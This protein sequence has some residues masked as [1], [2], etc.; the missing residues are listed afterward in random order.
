MFPV[1]TRR[2]LLLKLRVACSYVERVI[3]RTAGAIDPEVMFALIVT[4]GKRRYAADGDRFVSRHVEQEVA[5]RFN[6]S[7]LADIVRRHG[8]K[9]WHRV[10]KQERAIAPILHGLRLDKDDW[11]HIASIRDE[12]VGKLVATVKGEMASHPPP[13]PPVVP[14]KRRAVEESQKGVTGGDA[15]KRRRKRP[16]FFAPTP[17]GMPDG[18]W[19]S[20]RAAR[21]ELSLDTTN[22]TTEGVL[23]V[24][25]WLVGEKLVPY[26]GTIVHDP[27]GTPY[28]LFGTGELRTLQE[29]KESRYRTLWNPAR[30]HKT[31]K[32]TYEARGGD[33]VGYFT[34]VVA[35]DHIVLND[36]Q[37][38]P[39][40]SVRWF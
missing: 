24:V 21:G 1:A 33:R 26:A 14:T 35:E 18:A 20:A 4:D 23:V 38:I 40:P 16:E 10:L 28:V 11:S 5:H 36:G 6:V 25:E 2:Q 27:S 7:M 37:W 8:R 17:D 30:V 3:G 19:S 12:L 13:S 22:G 32:V 15:R 9:S 31:C 39:V 29:C 34:G